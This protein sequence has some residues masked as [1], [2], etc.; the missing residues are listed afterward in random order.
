MKNMPDN[1]PTASDPKLDRTLAAIRITG[2]DRLSLLQGQLTQDMN[3]LAPGKPLLAGWTTPKGRLMCLCWLLD[4]ENAVWMLVPAELCERIAQRLK[5]Y[6]LRADAQVE[7]SE[8]TV[9]PANR[10]SLTGLPELNGK[11][12]VITTNNCLY[13]DSLFLLEQAGLA[14]GPTIPTGDTVAWRLANIRAGLPSVWAETYETFVPQ[15]LNLD[16]LEAISFSK[17]CYVGQEIIARTQN[18]GRIKRRMYGFQAITGINT[19]PGDPIYAENGA[20]AGIVVDAI[21]SETATE[22]LAVIRIELLSQTLSLG[23]DGSITLEPVTLPYTVPE[24]I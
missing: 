10:A 20:T 8:L 2:S 24:T 18:L 17:G 15:M 5:M 13:N 7:T 19:L 22:L 14:I 12:E 21:A 16:L 1:N 23:E 3:E 6:V 11:S 9:Q 4:W